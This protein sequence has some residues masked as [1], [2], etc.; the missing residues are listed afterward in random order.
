MKTVGLK[1]PCTCQ[2]MTFLLR[3]F[4]VMVFKTLY[5]L[6]VNLL[7]LTISVT[8]CIVQENILAAHSMEGTFN[9][10]LLTCLCIQSNTVMDNPAVQQCLTVVN[11]EHIF[12]QICHRF[13][14]VLH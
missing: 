10:L 5:G 6:H 7:T 3:W 2:S 11:A 13:I 12:S 14:L 9:L 1:C 4:S 8:A